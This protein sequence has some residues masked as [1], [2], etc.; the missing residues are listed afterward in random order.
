MQSQLAYTRDFE[1]EADRNGLMTLQAAGFDVRG[2]PA[3]F[4]RLQRNSRL[5][6]NNAPAY[7]RTHPLTT[8][9]ITDMEN[10]VQGLGYRQVPDSLEFRL[11]QAKLLAL[12]GLCRRAV[13]A[14]SKRA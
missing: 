9:R 2:M 7:L 8:D 4:E 11:V 6:E 1:R 12:Q 10:R 14:G 13:R 5:Y 3:F